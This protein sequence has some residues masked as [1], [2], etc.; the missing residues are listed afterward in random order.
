MC[1]TPMDEQDLTVLLRLVELEIRHDA[2]RRER[3]LHVAARDYPPAADRL[4]APELCL[5]SLKFG[6]IILQARRARRRFPDHRSARLDERREP[7]EQRECH[8][9]AR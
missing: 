1:Q 2:E 8:S 9:L 6:P 5:Q 7:S 3:R 4:A